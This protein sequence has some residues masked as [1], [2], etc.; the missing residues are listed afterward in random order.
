MKQREN[1]AVG[2]FVYP[3]ETHFFG[4]DGSNMIKSAKSLNMPWFNPMHSP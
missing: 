1:S 4:D 3:I 2:Q